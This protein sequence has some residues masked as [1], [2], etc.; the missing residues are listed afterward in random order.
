[1]NQTPL[2]FQQFQ[3]DFGRRCRDPRAKRPTGVPAR[4]MKIY[5]A[6]LF[7]NMTGFLDACFPVC[8]QLIGDAR[9]RRINRAFFREWRSA[10]PLFREIPREFLHFLPTAKCALPPWFGELAHYEW[11]ELAVD[12]SSHPC[13][14]H[15]PQGDLMR[16]IP[17]I[18]PSLMNLTYAW[19]VHRIGPEYRPRKSV[20]VCLLVFRDAKDEVKFAEVNDLTARLIGRI[21]AHEENGVTALRWLADEVPESLACAVR[22]HGALI[23]NNLRDMGA[24]LGVRI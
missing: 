6:L 11:T 24:I 10:T 17:L 21:L 16:G 15:D 2:A 13:P 5:E 18:N 7:N 4:N 3:R 23:L 9:W 22:H 12:T 8:R 19:P 20:P 1:M 14:A